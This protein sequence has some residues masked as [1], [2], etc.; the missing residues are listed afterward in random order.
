MICRPSRAITNFQLFL[1]ARR[2]WPEHVKAEIVLESYRYGCSV[3]E[4]ARKHGLSG[5]QLHAWRRAAR[6]VLA[7]PDGDLLGLL[8]VVVEGGSGNDRNLTGQAPVVI[9]LEIEDVLVNGPSDFDSARLGRVI[10]GLGA[11]V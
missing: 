6:G 11:S 1:S 4:V 3:A 8:S 5:S 9:V 10:T 7:M 2:R